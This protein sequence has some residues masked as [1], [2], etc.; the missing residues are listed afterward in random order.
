LPATTR[1]STTSRAYRVTGSSCSCA[2][3]RLATAPELLVLV[4]L[5]LARQAHA[6]SAGWRETKL[7]A[8]RLDDL[9][10]LFGDLHR[11]VRHLVALLSLAQPGVVEALV[12][13]G[14]PSHDRQQAQL[15]RYGR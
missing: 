6:A 5:V 8:E 14:R 12:R 13:E 3:R 4:V 9:L 11:R 10:G 15:C 7:A 1:P 2:R